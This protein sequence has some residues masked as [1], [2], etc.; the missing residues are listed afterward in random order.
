MS[1]PRPVRYHP[2]LF[3]HT[4]CE[5]RAPTDEREFEKVYMRI[6]RGVGGVYNIASGGTSPLTN[7]EVE[8]IRLVRVRVW[9]IVEAVPALIRDVV[10][11]GASNTD[12]ARECLD[13]MWLELHEVLLRRIYM[14][15]ARKWA[16]RCPERTRLL[17]RWCVTPSPLRIRTHVIRIST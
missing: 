6:G 17:I 4:A 14:M 3:R 12:P 7:A 8:D 11:G 13:R 15:F 2:S 16:H 1:A 5:S 9:E 10:D